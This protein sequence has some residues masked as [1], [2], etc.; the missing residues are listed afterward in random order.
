MDRKNELLIRA[1]LV[2]LAFVIMATVITVRVV[3]VSVIEGE[4]WRKMSGVNVKVKP[5]YADRGNIYT[6]DGS[7]LATS[8]P[9]FEIRMDLMVPS[10]ELFNS[11]IDSLAYYLAKYLPSSKSKTEWKNELSEARGFKKPGYR[12]YPIAK[13]V[14][15]D[16]LSKMKRFPIFRRGRYGGGF[17][18]IKD[19]KRNK[20]YRELASRT[21]G[22]DREN[23]NKIGLEGYFDEFLKGDTDQKL[24]KR[25]PGGEWVP[26]FDPREIEEKSGAD[27]Y[28]TIDI[29]LQDIAHEE[30]VAAV[31][32]FGAEGGSVV[33]MDVETGAIK[34]ISNISRT[35]S[36]S[37]REVYNHAIGHLSEPGSTMKL[38]TVMAMF[39]DGHADLNTKVD[40]NGGKKRFYKLLM[41]DSRLHGKG[42][43]SLQHAFEISS[44]VG[45]GSLANRFYNKKGK[46]QDFI[47]RL[48][49]FGLNQKT[50]I[51]IKGEGDPFL[52]TPG[53]KDWY[54]T[55]IP[56]MA[57]GYEMMHTPLQTL[58]FY[59]AVANEGKLMKPY[60]VTKIV[61]DR[62]V[63]KSFKP[64]VLRHSIASQATIDKAKILLEGVVERGTGKS[65]QSDIVRLAGKTGTTSVDYAKGEDEKRHNAS[66]AG[67]FPANDPKYS[68]IV[69]IYKP[70]SAYYGS[71]VA[72]PV[73]K[74]IA[75][76]T[77]VLKDEFSE[78]I[79]QNDDLLA[80][81]DLPSYHT[82]FAPD[83]QE[84][85]N[86]VG[87]DYKKKTKGSWVK[88]DPSENKMLIN[89]GKISKDEVPDVKGMGLRDALYVLENLGLNVKTQGFG[90]VKKQ[91]I[92][93][94]T[95]LKGQEINIYLN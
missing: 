28:T 1:Y 63:K 83:Y 5:V 73:F 81:N 14:N 33:M 4:K 89:K 47:D 51:E 93:P 27:I 9:F 37:L 76:K 62:E 68:M 79:N 17:R 84:V 53:K 49:E 86:Y 21:I 58:M 92:R 65:F 35:K 77:F 15:F 16:L 48:N 55:T 36:G 40:L 38:A 72:G 24:M 85:F 56:W 82:G 31:D 18:A 50:G 67:Y 66:F 7:L 3:K 26:I 91:S 44:N 39:E 60:L 57:H 11:E 78:A 6:E 19:T 88:I 29:E 52:K 54:G 75:E 64:K 22:E 61:E 87:M 94:G 95:K 34:A 30:L 2:L 71:V 80:S 70:E 90:K 43:V 74:N 10:D 59:N 20:P 45:M 8:L 69:I 46:Q 32:S 42:I 23:A 25:I 12:Y 41:K 13:N